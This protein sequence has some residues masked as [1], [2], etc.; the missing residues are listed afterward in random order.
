M[1]AWLIAGAAHA[2]ISEDSDGFFDYEAYES[3]EEAEGAWEGLVDRLERLESVN[4]D[5]VG[6]EDVEDPS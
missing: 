3:K 2:I 6:D 1:G 4:A 5:A